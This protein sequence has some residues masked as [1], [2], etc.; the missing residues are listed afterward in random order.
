MPDHIHLLV[1][2]GPDAN[3]SSAVRRFKGRL[4]PTLREI[5]A[6]W[7][8]SF[9]DHRLRTAEDLLP[10]FLYIFLNPYRANLCNREQTWP[11]YWCAPDDWTWFGDMTS[12]SCP[13]LDWLC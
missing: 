9:Y 8:P 13:E 6:C 3:L 12:A 11:G 10:V 5:Q 4:T 7:Q 1:T 2:L